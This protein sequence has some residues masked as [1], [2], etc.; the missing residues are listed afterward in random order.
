MGYI[1]LKLN[2]KTFS[3]KPMNV[4]TI[5]KLLREINPTKSAGINNLAR[6][7]LKEGEQVL[8]EPIT[9]LINF[10]IYLPCFPDDCKIEK[11]KPI[12]K[13]ED[14]TNPK[15]YTLISLLPLI[16]KVIE[17]IITKLKNSLTKTR[18]CI[19]ISPVFISITQLIP[20]YHISI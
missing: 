16:S 4:A 13:K 12:Y 20:A 19:S 17:K 15:N 10:S 6:K 5:Q 9:E 18:F 14:K 1:A 11:L 3:F 7:F 2:G 8:A